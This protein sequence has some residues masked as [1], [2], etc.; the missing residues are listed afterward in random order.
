MPNKT[1]YISDADMPLFEKAQELYGTNLSSTL[2]NVLRNSIERRYG[3]DDD[4]PEEK[5]HEIIVKVGRNGCYIQQRF[6]GRQIAKWDAD[7]SDNRVYQSYQLFETKTGKYAL[8]SKRA[9]WENFNWYNLKNRSQTPS[10]QN[11]NG[12][13]QLEVFTSVG[14]F[15]DRIPED[16]RDIVEKKL[17]GINIVDL[18]I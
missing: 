12:V 6:T 2:V 13:C 8:Y 17:N 9:N 3:V 16:I 1:I 15:E 4:E 7:S 10:D 14:E 18:D 11:R 5:L